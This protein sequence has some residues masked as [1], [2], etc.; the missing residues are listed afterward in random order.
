MPDTHRAQSRTRFCIQGNVEFKRRNYADALAAVETLSLNRSDFLVS[1][2]GRSSTRD[3]A[4]LRDEIAR[5]RLESF[6]EFSGDEVPFSRYLRQLSSSDFILPLVDP[7]SDQYAQYL[8]EKIT[9]SMSMSLAFGVV[10]VAHTRAA[11]AY[12]VQ[13]YA[14]TY[15]DGGLADALRLAIEMPAQRRLELVAG[16]TGMRDRLLDT[17]TSNLKRSIAV[18]VDS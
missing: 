7:T 11:E 14:I 17:S 10:P 18:V 15:P 13:Q 16:M 1:V 8:M 5:R 2:V 6:F 4:A 3:G 9:S 12:G